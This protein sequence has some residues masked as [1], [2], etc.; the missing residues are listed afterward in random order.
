MLAASFWPLVAPSDGRATYAEHCA[1]CHGANL[2]GAPDWQQRLPDGRW[3]PPPHDATGHTWHH[4][5]AQ[6]FQIVRNGP[7]SI[8]GPQYQT[9]MPAFA[10]TL[11]DR[12]I[13][14]VLAYIKSTW[15]PDERAYQ[16]LM[17]RPPAERLQQ[18]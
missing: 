11:S 4:S 16:E 18:P 10:G 7:Q 13:A 12:D 3:P 17:N 5:D 15:P 9:D 14:T 1:G 6:L 2:E 8:L